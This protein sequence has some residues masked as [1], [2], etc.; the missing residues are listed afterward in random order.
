MEPANYQEVNPFL[1]EAYTLVS[2]T[3]NKSQVRQLTPSILEIISEVIQNNGIP[4]AT[5]LCKTLSRLNS[6][7]EFKLIGWRFNDDKGNHTPLKVFNST[8]VKI[9]SVKEMEMTRVIRRPS[10]FN[11]DWKERFE[12]KNNLNSQANSDTAEVVEN[13][14]FLDENAIFDEQWLKEIDSYNSDDKLNLLLA[15]PHFPK[16]IKHI[17]SDPNLDFN[18]SNSY[19][20]LERFIDMGLGS[21]IQLLLDHPNFV[22][23][24][25]TLPDIFD[26]D[27]DVLNVLLNNR[28][29]SV[30]LM[31]NPVFMESLLKHGEKG[32]R[33]ADGLGGG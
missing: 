11:S 14:P 10:N 13:L 28:Q 7:H 30:A 19:P 5:K 17:L 26:L 22:F 32:K 2:Q 29:V 1:Q 20:I 31:G 21:E 23:D 27:D 24:H 33:I 15:V 3:L 8:L 25:E 4:E 16:L 9:N 12:K 18:K 6:S